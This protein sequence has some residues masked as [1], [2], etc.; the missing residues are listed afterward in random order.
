MLY[1]GPAPSHPLRRHGVIFDSSMASE[2]RS[3]TSHAALRR[4]SSSPFH[5]ADPSR[6][7]QLH[8]SR[9][10]GDCQYHHPRRPGN[11]GHAHGRAASIFSHVLRHLATAHGY[12]S[13]SLR[14]TH[15]S[16]RGH[17]SLVGDADANGADRRLLLHSPPRASAWAWEKRPMLSARQNGQRLVRRAAIAPR[18]PASSTPAPPLA[19]PWRRPCLPWPC[20]PLAGAACSCLS[21]SPA[22]LLCGHLV[23][24]YRDRKTC[25]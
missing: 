3:P 10:A 22:L 20:L 11:L 5:R 25:R 23:R 21:A 18:R 16:G 15:R 1:T 19:R 17:V 12:S 9:V 2:S 8:R 24:L 7:C 14:R 6:H 13:R 4:F